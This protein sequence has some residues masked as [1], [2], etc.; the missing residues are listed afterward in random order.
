MIFD[1]FTYFFPMINSDQIQRQEI[2]AD[3]MEKF[4]FM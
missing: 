3:Y 4:L 2:K 1:V